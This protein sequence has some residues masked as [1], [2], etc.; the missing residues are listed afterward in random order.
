MAGETIIAQNQIEKPVAIQVTHR[1][2]VGILSTA[3]NVAGRA[4]SALS[5]VERNLTRITI[6][7]TQ[8]EIKKSITVQI[9]Q[10]HAIGVPPA[11]A[12]LA[13]RIESASAI[14]QRNLTRKT[15]VA[16]NKIKRPIAVQVAHR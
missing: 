7:I 11:V 3:G 1:Y 6:V 10:G 12:D 13:Q 5:I 9:A 15:V 16:K 14:V 2:T 8:D 4:K